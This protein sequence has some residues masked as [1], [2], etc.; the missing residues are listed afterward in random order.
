MEHI[1]RP[2]IIWIFGD[3]M[4]AQAMTHRGDRNVFTPNM[5]RLAAEGISFT[6]AVAGTP[7]CTPFRGSLITGKYPHRS[8]APG[9]DYPLSKDVKT[10]AHAFRGNGYRTCWIGKWHLDGKREDLDLT[11]EKN[12]T[13]VRIIPPERRGGFEDWWAYENNNA[14]FDCWVHSDRLDGDTELFRLPGYETDCLTDILIAWLKERVT[15]YKEQPFFA[16]LSVQPPHDPYLAPEEYIRNHDP[17]TIEFRPNV[18]QV[19]WVTDIARRELAGYYAAIERLDWNLGRIRNALDD[20]GIAEDTYLVFFSDH[21]D[22]HG[23]HGQF[24]KTAPWEEA[25]RIPFIV[26]GPRLKYGNSVNIEYPINHVDIAPTTLGL[27]GI[28]KPELM[29]GYDYSSLILKEFAHS[30]KKENSEEDFP[31]SAYLS[32]PV[33]PSDVGH[34]VDRPFRGI[35]TKD[36]WKY[37]A[38]EGQPWLMFNLN[39]DPYEMVNIAHNVIFKDQ[40]KLLHERLARWVSETDD[41]FLL[42]VID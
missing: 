23:S 35:V 11:K 33:P 34:T 16:S 12:Q 17:L 27:C 19:K 22:L 21:G 10:I 38:L 9:H 13:W 6:H 30:K 39:D 41:E 36:G 5:D 42:P 25:I 20:L 31:D 8:T 40:R 2:N 18:P 1:K 7:L 3:Q 15:K 26:G 32:L 24:R 4:R 14:P 28:K 37:V 29:E